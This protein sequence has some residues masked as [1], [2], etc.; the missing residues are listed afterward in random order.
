MFQQYVDAFFVAWV[1]LVS[2]EG[3]TNY[4]HMLGAGHI[5]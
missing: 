1:D 4:V 3:V 5:G 2:R